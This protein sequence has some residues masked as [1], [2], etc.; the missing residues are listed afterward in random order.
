MNYLCT[1]GFIIDLL[2][3]LPWEVI[4]ENVGLQLLGLL[5]LL[6]VTRIHQVISNMNNS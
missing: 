3:T 4:S 6:R 5:K 1:T 2:S